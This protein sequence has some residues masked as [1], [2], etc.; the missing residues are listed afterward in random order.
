MQYVP[1]KNQ[2]LKNHFQLRRPELDNIITILFNHDEC[3]PLRNAY[4]CKCPCSAVFPIKIYW[5]DYQY[6]WRNAL[7][8]GTKAESS[9][10]CCR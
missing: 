7:H 5:L 4:H 6:G 9:G 3:S 8:L 1:E 2:F 10:R